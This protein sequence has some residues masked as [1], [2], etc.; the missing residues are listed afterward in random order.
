MSSHRCSGGLMDCESILEKIRIHAATRTQVVE[1]PRGCRISTPLLDSSGD[2]ITV[3]VDRCS[4]PGAYHVTDG[5]RLNGLLFESSPAGP[6]AVDRRMVASIAERASLKFDDDHRV[7]YAVADDR[8]LG[9]WTFEVARTVATVASITPQRRRSRAGRKLSTYVIGQLE[10]ELLSQGLLENIRGPR[11]IRGV[12]EIERRVDLSY[13]ARREPLGDQE[14]FGDIFVIAADLGATDPVRPA[15]DTVIA[16]HDLSALDDGPVVRIVHGTV[17]GAGGYGETTERAE[18]ARRLIE[19]VA[20]VSGIEE[21]SW[22]DNASRAAFVQITKRE[23][24][25]GAPAG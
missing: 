14:R 7:F 21:Y 24:A 23:L 1:T 25:L 15:R 20:S 19:S 9:Y 4:E 5:G 16:A 12:T 18:H 10:K 6:S 11:R 22:D 13:R 17:A 2:V 8:T 3:N